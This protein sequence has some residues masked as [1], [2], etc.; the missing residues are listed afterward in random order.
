LKPAKVAAK[1][2]MRGE[3]FSIA[4]QFVPRPAKEQITLRHPPELV[5]A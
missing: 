2:A 3:N 1:R 4:I 5:P